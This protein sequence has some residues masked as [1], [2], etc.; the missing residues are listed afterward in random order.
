MHALEA[1]SERLVEGT[2]RR[3][4][5]GMLLISVLSLLSAERE[6]QAFVCLCNNYT[7]ATLIAQAK[8]W[9]A[10]VIKRNAILGAR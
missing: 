10:M 4:N 9:M 3:R 5:L 2:E 1:W 8:E 7:E 6:C